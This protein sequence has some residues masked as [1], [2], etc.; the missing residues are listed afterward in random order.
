MRA[1]PEPTDVVTYDLDLI[2]AGWDGPTDE[3]PTMREMLVYATGSPD[4]GLYDDA[5]RAKEFEETLERWSAPARSD[6]ALTMTVAEA[7]QLH[8]AAMAM[9]EY[10]LQ[11]H[12][13][14]DYEAV[15]D[16]AAYRFATAGKILLPVLAVPWTTL[17]EE[18]DGSNGITLRSG[19][20]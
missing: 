13:D 20:Q 19:A 1:A 6:A 12:Y 16:P 18:C 3:W 2:K 15:D 10:A 9:L 7:G 8:D 4:E 17:A 14:A 5:E 11:H